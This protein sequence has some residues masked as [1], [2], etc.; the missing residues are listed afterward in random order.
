MRDKFKINAQFRSPGGHWSP[1]LRI[2]DKNK[3]AAGRGVWAAHQ[4]R[5]AVLPAG[6]EGAGPGLGD[7]RSAEGAEGPSSQLAEQPAALAHR[8]CHDS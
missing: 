4:Q 3:S 6:A 7:E 5:A 1:V 8:H 2:K